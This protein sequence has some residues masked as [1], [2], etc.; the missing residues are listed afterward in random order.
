MC[1]GALYCTALYQCPCPVPVPMPCCRAMPSLSAVPHPCVS[2]ICKLLR[3]GAP[4]E[5]AMTGCI[6][7]GVASRYLEYGPQLWAALLGTCIVLRRVASWFVVCS[8]FHCGLGLSIHSCRTTITVA[9]QGPVQEH[10][11]CAVTAYLFTTLGVS[12]M[13]HSR[14][15]SHLAMC[16]PKQLPIGPPGDEDGVD[17]RNFFKL[18]KERVL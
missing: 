18:L 16:C 5:K 2:C 14:M 4:T 15:P 17:D 6:T 9:S 13:Y 8:L 3:S 11:R 12:P 10:W 7:A 1:L